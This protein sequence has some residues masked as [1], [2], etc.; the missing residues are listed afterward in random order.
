MKLKIIAIAVVLSFIGCDLLGG[1]DDNKDKDVSDNSSS[2][3]KES[4]SS[5]DEK[6]S[7][8][9][10]KDVESSSSSVEE[11]SSSSV[12][13]SSSSSVESSSSSIEESSSSSVVDEPAEDVKAVYMWNSTDRESFSELDF[14]CSGSCAHVTGIDSSTGIFQL[15]VY[16]EETSVYNY[17]WDETHDP[18][19]DPST[20]SLD[21]TGYDYFHLKLNTT[22]TIEIG[23]LWGIE[24]SGWN[25][26]GYPYWTDDEETEVDKTGLGGS[27]WK[28]FVA[29]DYDEY[30][31]MK[32]DWIYENDDGDTLRIDMSKI[33]Q[34]NIRRPLAISEATPS[35]IDIIELKFTKEKP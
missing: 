4:S 19:A 9:S 8:S 30:F 2:S 15:S 12:P 3:V 11:S 25:S 20:Y 10:S 31:S 7:S 14:W 23:I 28:E 13:E 24:P 35:D 16:K 18:A 17:S 33:K 6:P 26:E 34:V 5:S 1:G 29:G 27:V 32:E 22:D 21:F